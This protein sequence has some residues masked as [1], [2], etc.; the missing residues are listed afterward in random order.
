[1]KKMFHNF[2]IIEQSNIDEYKYPGVWAMLGM[3]KEGDS[4]KYICLNVGKSE[5]IGD[6]LKID[7]ARLECFTPFKD[8]IY[9]NQFN[10]EKFS[11]REY[12]TRQDWLYKEISE[13]Y[14]PIIILVTN[15]TEK[16]YTIEKYF[17][18]STKAI[19][20]VSNGRYSPN[21]VIDNFEISKI[22]ND[23][24][25]SKIDKLLIKKIDEFKKWYDNQ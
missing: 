4:K 19:Y 12:A 11:Y 9:K 15:E 14:E 21:R 6:E 1:M 13:K 22:R 7:F 10:E 3:K 25:I 24:D 2:E 18:Y 16:L 8:K 17:A 5:C 23:I 20:W